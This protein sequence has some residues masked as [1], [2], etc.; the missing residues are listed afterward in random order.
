M[1]YYVM[2]SLSSSLSVQEWVK[3]FT[4]MDKGNSAHQARMIFMQLNKSGDGVLTSKDLIPIIFNRATKEQLT[5][6]LA[7]VM[8]EIIQKRNDEY[9]LTPAE[10]AQLFECYD[11]EV[12][13]FVPVSVIRDRIRAM[14]L[15]EIAHF[16]FMD[17]IVKLEEDE[18]LNEQEFARML[19]PYSVR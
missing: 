3:L 1:L 14:Q 6:I 13:G 9:C 10:V 16:G 4:S 2:N 11:V 5:F 17:S 19:R 18:M 7:Y 12:I 8:S 15:P